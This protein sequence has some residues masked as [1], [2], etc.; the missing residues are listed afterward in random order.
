MKDYVQAID[1]GKVVS[2]EHEISVAHLK[3]NPHSTC[4][5]V[6]LKHLITGA[7]TNGKLSCHLVRIQAGCEISEHVHADKLE[8]HEVLSGNGKGILVKKEIPYLAGT[9]VVIPANEPH[10]VIAGGEDVYLLA[11]FTPALV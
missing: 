4:Q 1:E 3:W 6:M 7:S 9:C 10:K 5:G 2:L 8:L 11:K